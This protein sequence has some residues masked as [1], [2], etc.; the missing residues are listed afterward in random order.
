RG[1]L[2]VTDEVHGELARHRGGNDGEPERLARRVRER[3]AV[4]EHELAYHELALEATERAD[5]RAFLQATPHRRRHV[6]GERVG[7]AEREESEHVIHVAVREYE[8]AD[9]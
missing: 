5:E 8:R 1:A 3:S 6:E 2:G 7:L 4:T 9:G